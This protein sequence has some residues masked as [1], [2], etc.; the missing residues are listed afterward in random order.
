MQNVKSGRLCV[1][2]SEEEIRHILERMSQAGC[3]SMSTYLRNLALNG[4]II[5]LDLPEIREMTAQL[6]LCTHELRALRR[7]GTV[8]DAALLKTEHRLAQVQALAGQFLRK[9]SALP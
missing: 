3:S 5:Q 6:G 9:L 8:S 7:S 1:Y 4:L 2:C